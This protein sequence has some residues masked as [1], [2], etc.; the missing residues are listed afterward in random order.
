MNTPP[1]N[2]RLVPVYKGS[3]PPDTFPLDGETYKMSHNFG[4][5]AV[6]FRGRLGLRHCVYLRNET[7]ERAMSYAA[8][9]AENV[10]AIEAE[11]WEAH[12]V[13]CHKA[14]T[15]SEEKLPAGCGS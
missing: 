13:P 9:E 2:L 14:T 11:V 6:V 3:C 10:E 4:G 7:Q 5:Y 12:A 8:S 1:A 15:W